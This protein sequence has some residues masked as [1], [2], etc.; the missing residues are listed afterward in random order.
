MSS[1]MLIERICDD[2]AYVETFVH[3]E[4]NQNGAVACIDIAKAAE[5]RGWTH[6]RFEDSKLM[7]LDYCGACT[8]RRQQRKK[9]AVSSSTK[10]N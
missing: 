3:L 10:A 2:C 7:T 6:R 8:A 1:R 5:Q 9:P 4:R